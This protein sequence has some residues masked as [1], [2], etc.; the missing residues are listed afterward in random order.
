MEIAQLIPIS[1]PRLFEDN[2]RRLICPHCQGFAPRIRYCHI[3]HGTGLI[4]QDAQWVRENMSHA[5]PA[6]LRK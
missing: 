6:P 5:L 3:C 1:K 2:Y 4:V